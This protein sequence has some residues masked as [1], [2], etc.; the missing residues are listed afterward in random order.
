MDIP[1][2]ALYCHSEHFIDQITEEIIH[3]SN[4]RSKIPNQEFYRHVNYE[5]YY[6]LGIYNC[7]STW[8]AENVVRKFMLQKLDLFRKSKKKKV[9]MMKLVIENS[10]VKGYHEYVSLQKDL[11]MLIMTTL[12]LFLT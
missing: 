3:R 6:G 2:A 7:K 12:I 5:F 4:N 10:N 11:E 1:S 8:S 9:H